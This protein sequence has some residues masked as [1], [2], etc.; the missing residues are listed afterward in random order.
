M[1]TYMHEVFPHHTL[2]RGAVV[3]LLLL[4]AALN[5]LSPGWNADMKKNQHCQTNEEHNFNQAG[6]SPG[7]VGDLGH[8]IG[9]GPD[10]SKL[11]RG[12]SISRSS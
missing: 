6:K 7:V 11:Y 3:G 9:L 12:V 2:K 4:S 8:R 5:R 10:F 1:R